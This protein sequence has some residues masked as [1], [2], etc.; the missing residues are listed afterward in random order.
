MGKIRDRCRQYGTDE[1]KILDKLWDMSKGHLAA[2]L[3]QHTECIDPPTTIGVNFSVH[4]ETKA[5]KIS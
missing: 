3:I 2:S 5:M 1:D 4:R